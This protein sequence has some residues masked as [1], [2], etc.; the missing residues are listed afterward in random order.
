MSLHL[1]FVCGKN[2]RRSPTAEQL[3]S[4]QPGIEC[5]SAGVD[6]DADIQVTPELVEWA[7]LVLVMEN[8]HK[9]KI[10]TRFP[11][12]TRDKRIVS[13]DIPDR[14]E[15]MDVELVELLYARIGALLP[16]RA[17]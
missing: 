14:F 7:D 15:Y 16:G 3:F 6:H 2:R 4:T 8:A 11:G 13:L 17:P 9:R 12:S 1:L 5:T 10:S